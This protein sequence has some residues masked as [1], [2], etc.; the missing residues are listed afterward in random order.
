MGA[1]EFSTV[2]L[3]K[4]AMSPVGE[5]KSDFEIVLEIAQKMGSERGL[6]QMARQSMNG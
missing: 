2:G 1:N 4:Q 6:C 3:Q 5:S